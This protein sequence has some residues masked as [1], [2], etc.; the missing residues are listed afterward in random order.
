MNIN[1]DNMNIINNIIEVL[2]DF[3]DKYDIN[4]VN[5]STYIYHIF[6]NNNVDVFN[7]IDDDIIIKDY[8][9]VYSLLVFK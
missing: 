5:I 7:D 2:K 9:Q 4:D 1:N 6:E 3:N 8:L